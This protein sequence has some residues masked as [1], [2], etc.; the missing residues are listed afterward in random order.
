M[1]VILKA[2]LTKGPMKAIYCLYSFFNK[3]CQK[4]ID[5]EDMLNLDNEINETLCMFK[6]FYFPTFFNITINLSIH[7][8]HE[9]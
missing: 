9:A 6:R 4:I 8:R 3:L 2:L 1:P 7:L 5:R